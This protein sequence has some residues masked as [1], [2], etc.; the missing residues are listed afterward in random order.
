MG[1]SRSKNCSWALA[2]FK[3]RD[4][5]TRHIMI[6]FYTPVKAVLSSILVELRLSDISPPVSQTV[7]P[8]PE[9]TT[10]VSEITQTSPPVPETTPPVSEDTRTSSLV[11]EVSRPVSEIS[12]TSLVVFKF[13]VHSLK[14]LKDLINTWP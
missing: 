4:L 5:K 13:Y 9:T 11:P 3:F 14:S 6:L 1:G 12:T 8:V 10:T 7:P 2:A